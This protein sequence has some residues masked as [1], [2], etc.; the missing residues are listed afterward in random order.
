LA[1]ASAAAGLF[2]YV[3]FAV[4]TR[5]LGPA[6]AAPVSVLWTYWGIAAAV[7]T[8]SVQHW[9][10][11]TVTHDGHGGTVIR[12]LPVFAGM[13]VVL[14]LLVGAVAYAFGET[15]FGRDGLGFPALAAAITAGSLFVGLVRGALSAQDRYLATAASVVGENALRVTAAGGVALAGGGPE[16]FGAALAAGA[17]VGLVWLPVFGTL[18]AGKRTAGTEGFRR[19][20]ARAVGSV[21]GVAGGTLIAQL[22]LTGAPV[23]LAAI[24]GAPVA[25]TSLFVALAVWR[26]PYIVALGVTPQLTSYFTR[27]V[28]A[29]R[30]RQLHVIRGLMVLGV[31]AG[32]LAA[33]FLGATIMPWVLRVAFGSGVQLGNEALAVLGVGT[34]LALANIVQV[35]LLLAYGRSRVPTIGWVVALV[36]AC[37]WLVVSPM[38]EESR[39]VAAFLVAQVVAFVG[40]FL[41]CRGGSGRGLAH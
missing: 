9:T 23:V 1:A 30:T 41:S 10:V 32:S 34:V 8:F 7:L 3:F 35:L 13:A 37:G 6:G 33:A 38:P 14:S 39:V 31:V 20:V 18:A 19:T 29:E 5:S 21:S 4:A 28:V 24:G 16:A 15:L 17:L 40:L 22:V 2:L 27:L 36:A 25:V 12:T 11:R 26:A